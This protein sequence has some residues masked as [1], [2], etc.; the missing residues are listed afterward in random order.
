M[1]PDLITGRVLADGVHWLGGCLSAS[2]EG[3]EV[4]YHV[5]SYLVIGSEAS[6]LVDTGDPAH[7]ETV[8]AQLGPCTGR[9]D[10]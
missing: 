8:L 1:S 7:R 6:I 5:S 9:A 2:A 3:Q 4:H 10:A